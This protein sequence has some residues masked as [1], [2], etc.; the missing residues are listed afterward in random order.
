[1][2]GVKLEFEDD[3]LKRIA[4]LAIKKEIGARGLRSIIEKAMQNVMFSIP[5]RADA[6]K[7]VVTSGVID[8]TEEAVVYGNKNKK[9]A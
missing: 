2:D 7:V 4:E 8:G 6:K 3:A 5:D 9:I 1:M